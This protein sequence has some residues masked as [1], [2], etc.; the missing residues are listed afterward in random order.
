MTDKGESRSRSTLGARASVEI[1]RKSRWGLRSLIRKPGGIA[2]DAM[3]SNILMSDISRFS[4]TGTLLVSLV[5]HV[6]VVGLTSIGFVSLC[7]KYDSLHPRQVI[8][9]MEKQKERESAEA[10]RAAALEKADAGQD[11]A[12]AKPQGPD[13]AKSAIEREIEKTSDERPTDTNV[14][15]DLPQ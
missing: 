6:V 7:V 8:A 14:T 15:V 2:P 1:R 13:G 10:T 4:L 12:S 9:Q 11:G 3:E 5:V